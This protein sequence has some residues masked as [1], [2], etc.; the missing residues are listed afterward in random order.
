MPSYRQLPTIVPAV[1]DGWEMGNRFNVTANGGYQ[2][3]ASSYIFEN[4]VQTTKEI[5]FH[6]GTSN[7]D[8]KCTKK[9]AFKMLLHKKHASVK[10][11]D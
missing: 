9:E 5:R 4:G 6:R 11:H 2:L 3:S 1:A 8:T 10:L 7:G